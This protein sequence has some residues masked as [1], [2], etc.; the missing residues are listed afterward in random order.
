MGFDIPKKKLE[1]VK[2]VK[3]R[4]KCG[5][6][7]DLKLMK[8][9]LFTKFKQWEYEQ[10]Y[11][12]YINLDKETEENGM[13]FF[14]FEKDLKLKKVIVGCRSELTRK[15]IADALGE[16]SGKIEVFKARAAYKTFSVVRNKDEKLWA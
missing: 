14:D 5:G 13:Y 2:Y 16:L 9:C 10:E 7:P 8:K 11:R 3:N 1:E 12:F 4:I 6:S 15:D